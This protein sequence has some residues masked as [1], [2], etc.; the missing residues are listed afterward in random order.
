M[1]LVRVTR[2]S[3]SVKVSSAQ[4]FPVLKSNQKFLRLKIQYVSDVTWMGVFLDSITGDQ[5]I[6][7]N[8]ENKI[9]IRLTRK[10]RISSLFMI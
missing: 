5:L 1:T 8:N 4:R 2:R 10:R 7:K 9:T 3:K 6:K